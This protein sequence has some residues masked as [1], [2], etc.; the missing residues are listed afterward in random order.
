MNKNIDKWGERKSKVGVFVLLN[1]FIL[2]TDILILFFFWLIFSNI[3]ASL[4][5]FFLQ[6]VNAISTE[7]LSKYIKNYVVL[8]YYR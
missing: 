2:G 3:F 7:G 1:N 6:L 5:V 8:S 4:E